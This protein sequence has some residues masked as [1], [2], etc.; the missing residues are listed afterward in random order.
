[1]YCIMYMKTKKHDKAMNANSNSSSIVSKYIGIAI[2]IIG[3]AYGYLF[4]LIFS[5]LFNRNSD[6]EAI[7]GITFS[8]GSIIFYLLLILII[9]ANNNIGLLFYQGKVKSLF[10]MDDK[11]LTILSFIT[12]IVFIFAAWYPFETIPELYTKFQETNIQISP[13]TYIVVL[14]I[15]IVTSTLYQY[16]KKGSKKKNTA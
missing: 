5:Y 11:R 14:I 4:D 6:L 9:T 3:Y 16:L 12:A 8:F 1:M 10:L 7:L 15:S 13:L 2:F